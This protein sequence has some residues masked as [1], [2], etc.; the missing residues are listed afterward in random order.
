MAQNKKKSV[1]KKGKTQNKNTKTQ[2]KDVRKPL[3]S[4]DYKQVVSLVGFFFSVF[5]AAVVFIEAGSVWG[6]LR[7]FFFGLFGLNA[8]IVPF[9]LAFISVVSALGKDTRK[10]KYRVI[11]GFVLFTL[12]VSFLHIVRVDATLTYGEQ[13]EQGYK[14]FKEFSGV[15]THYGYGVFGAVFGGVPLLLTGGNKLAA[16]VI[17]LLLFLILLMIFSGTTLLKLIQSLKAPAEVVSDYAGEKIEDLK[18]TYSSVSED[19]HERRAKNAD[20]RRRET[21]KKEINLDIPLDDDV[22]IPDKGV[23]PI[24]TNEDDYLD[25]NVQMS[26]IIDLLENDGT[27]DEVAVPENIPEEPEYEETSYQDEQIVELIDVFGEKSV[28][29][30][31]I[32]QETVEYT[33]ESADAEDVEEIENIGGFIEPQEESKPVVEYILP[34]ADILDLPKNSGSTG[35]ASE[36][37][38]KGETIV[39][40]LK[41]FGVGTRIV[42]IC[43]SPSV[44]DGQ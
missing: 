16:G 11:E 21:V 8:F 17:T 31:E 33:E 30:E 18:T 27:A 42:E 13:I 6:A 2:R 39:R 1:Q 4:K 43:Q 29:V 15:G 40:T 38:E 20:K 9:F 35:S 24:L 44:Q 32:S 26:D 41:S 23:D 34:S 3:F 5:M 28:E 36:L 25:R 22:A 14:T 7:N 10:Y 37:R 12:L 19:I